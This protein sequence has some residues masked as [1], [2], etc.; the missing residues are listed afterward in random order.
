MAKGVLFSP[1]AWEEFLDWHGE[2]SVYRRLTVMIDE[3]RRTPFEGQ[4][5]PKRLQGGDKLMAR[6]LTDKH[7]L[8]YGVSLENILII[9]CRGHYDDK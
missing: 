3:C 4:G 7:R 2:I 8:V 6:R 5:K 1:M 9:R